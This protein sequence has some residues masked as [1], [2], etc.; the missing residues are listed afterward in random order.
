M[1]IIKLIEGVKCTVALRRTDACTATVV[2]CTFIII[3]TCIK[4]Y[5][6]EIP[7]IFHFHIF[8]LTNPLIMKTVIKATNVHGIH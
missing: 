7:Y 8:T 6:K 3:T 5:F 4:H 1:L 2:K